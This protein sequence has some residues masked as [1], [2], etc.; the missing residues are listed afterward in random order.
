MKKNKEG[1]RRNGVHNIVTLL[2][3]FNLASEQ[4]L[5]MQCLAFPDSQICSSNSTLLVRN[6]YKFFRSSRFLRSESL[7]FLEFPTDVDIS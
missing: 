7:F 6:H 1:L 4:T 5:Q 2:Q 3:S